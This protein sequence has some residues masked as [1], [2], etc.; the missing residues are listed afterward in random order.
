MVFDYRNPTASGPQRDE[1]DLGREALAARVAL[2]GEPFRS[3]FETETLHAKLT[4]LGFRE[5]EDLGPMLDPGA[6]LSEP[7]RLL[8]QQRRPYRSRDGLKT[9]TCAECHCG[10][11]SQ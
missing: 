11:G 3:Q 9:A 1:Y 4:A 10:I 6:L 8:A 7:G 5:V 2:P